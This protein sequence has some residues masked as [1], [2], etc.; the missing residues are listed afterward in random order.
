MTRLPGGRLVLLA[1]AVLATACTGAPADDGLR[2]AFAR[3]LSA[4]RFV[5]AFQRSGD[6]LTFTAPRPDGTPSTWRVH[7]DNTAI[8]QNSGTTQPYKGTVHS[9]WY[10]DGEKVEITGRDSNLPI[11]LTSNGLSQECWAFWEA[12]AKRWSWE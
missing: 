11:E 2:D 7:I 5:S 10:V 12:D 9:S 1:F 4:N 3:Q 8:T 6:T